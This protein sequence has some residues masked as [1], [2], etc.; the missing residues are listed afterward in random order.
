MRGFE[1]TTLLDRLGAA[2][3]SEGART[4][5]LLD[6]LQAT[7]HVT[8]VIRSGDLG[9]AVAEQTRALALIQA[10]PTDEP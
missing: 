4:R 10:T 9:G 5:Q 7:L 6:S 2:A 1:S 8:E 3:S